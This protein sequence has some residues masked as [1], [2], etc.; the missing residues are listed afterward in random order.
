MGNSNTK[1][2]FRLGYLQLGEKSIASILESNPGYWRALLADGVSFLEICS[3]I[4]YTEVLALR[5]R[6]PANLIALV[7]ACLEV[8]EAAAASSSASSA[9]PSSSDQPSPPPVDETQQSATSVE[10]PLFTPAPLTAEPRKFIATATYVLT[11]VMSILFALPKVAVLSTHSAD[12]AAAFLRP[13]WLH[14]SFADALFWGACASSPL[15]LGARLLNSLIS[16]YLLPTSDVTVKIAL[17][18]LLLVTLSGHLHK[19]DADGVEL[20]LPTAGESPRLSLWT[21]HLI[22]PAFPSANSLFTA[23]LS[24]IAKFD[25]VGWGIPYNHLFSDRL[26]E[27]LTNTVLQVMILLLTPQFTTFVSPLAHSIL[28]CARASLL[29]VAGENSAAA[30]D[31]GSA[32]ALQLEDLVLSE[33]SVDAPVP[34]SFLEKIRHLNHPGQFR[35][36]LHAV[37]KLLNYP[38]IA[39]SSL[40]PG[41]VK[42][43]NN[44]EELLMFLW[45]VIQENHLFIAFVTSS[46]A[47]IEALLLPL[48]QLFLENRSDS[49]YNGLIHIST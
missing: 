32:E 48:L 46:L 37:V 22:G 1:E 47:D 34:N 43:T 4:N 42:S 19:K 39:S 13:T 21:E 9:E 29:S 33:M 7:T 14:V 15:T 6:H 18:R 24:V 45:I 49:T 26:S 25:P 3:L 41:S 12:S 10:A 44:L 5:D 28:D 8:I 27:I 31:R 38:R 30:A 11:R 40:L 36:L 16:L 2:G 20:E 35:P 23:A 17:L